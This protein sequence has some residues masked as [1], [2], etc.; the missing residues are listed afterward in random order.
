MNWEKFA[1]RFTYLDDEAKKVIERLTKAASHEDLEAI[2]KYAYNNGYDD[3]QEN[4]YHEGYN[5]GERDTQE[6]ENW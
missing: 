2:I 5:D 1:N 4:G 3:G 6:S